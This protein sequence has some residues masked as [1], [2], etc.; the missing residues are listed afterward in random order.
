M[1][2]EISVLPDAMLVELDRTG[3]VP[4]YHQLA[5]M[6]ETAI[7][8]GVLKP[9]ARLENE[10]DLSVRLRLSRPT[11][12]RAIQELVDKGL[13]VRRRG[14]GTQVVQGGVTRNVEL[15]S[16]YDDLQAAGRAPSTSVLSLQR[17]PLPAEAITALGLPEKSEGLT[18]RRLRKA[19]E[20]PLALMNNALPEPLADID[21]DD[22]AKHGLYELLRL[23]GIT[24]RVAT[25]RI[26]ARTATAEEARALE[27]APGSAV[28]TMSRTGFDST[29]AAVEFGSHCYR[30]DRYAFEVTLVNR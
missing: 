2:Q 23:R 22:L 26:G 18:I 17:G 11:V 1:P 19:D 24:V 7:R 4:M 21:A 15:S 16:L 5:S 14:I 30:P 20:A 9:G 28:L 12:R 25:Q 29:G 3:P 10:L 8:D 13:V 6:L 27:L